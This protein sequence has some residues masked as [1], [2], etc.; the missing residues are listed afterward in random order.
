MKLTNVEIGKPVPDFAL[1]GGEGQGIRLS[2]YRGQKTV[3]Y[4]YPKDST[5]ACTQEACDFR[6]NYAAL[7]AAGAAVLGISPDGAKSHQRFAAK[8]E[9]PFELL[10][11]DEHRVSELFG[12]WQMKKLYGREYMGIVRSTFL[13]DEQGIL[14]KEWRGLR[15]KGH[16]QDVLETIKGM[17]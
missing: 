12:V 1:L 3:V 7:T 14:V 16:V 6:D 8:Q 2:D 4:F 5:P 13:I 10:T 15:V 17:E 11:D 9:L